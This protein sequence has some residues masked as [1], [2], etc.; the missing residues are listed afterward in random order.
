[1][2]ETK[3]YVETIG[4]AY[5][6]VGQYIQDLAQVSPRGQQRS[7]DELSGYKIQK[8]RELLILFNNSTH[9][10]QDWN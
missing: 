1:M 8:V 5:S 10:D 9:I 7:R 2:Q 3:V 4:R 6:F